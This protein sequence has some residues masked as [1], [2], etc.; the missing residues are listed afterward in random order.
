MTDLTW[1]TV[2]LQAIAA[3]NG[4]TPKPETETTI[5]DVFELAPRAVLRAIDEVADAVQRGEARSGWA[6]LRT[7]LAQSAQPVRDTTVKGV[8]ERARHI[9]QAETWMH[10]AGIHLGRESEVEDELFG[11]RGILRAWAKDDTLRQRMLDLWRD[12]RHIGI[13]LEREQLVHCGRRRIIAA[14][15]ARLAKRQP[16]PQVDT[17]QHV[18][19]PNLELVF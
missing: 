8:D 15:R 2:R 7:R 14:R 10:N 1:S 16:E 11:D 3:F 13:R 9:Q 17:E 4:E 5:I 18:H 19:D 12:T 6:I